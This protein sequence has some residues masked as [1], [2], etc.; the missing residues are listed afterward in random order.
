MGIRL[1]AAFTLMTILAVSICTNAFAATGRTPGQFAVSPTGTAQYTIPIWTPPG[2]RGVQPSLSLTYDS[3]SP[4][5]I[6]GVGW[7]L[8][9]VSSIY[10]CNP[11]YAQDGTPGA[12]TLTTADRFCMDGARLRLTSSDTLSNY[13]AVSTTY[14]TEVANFSL[15]TASATAAGNGPSYFTVQAKNG[16]TYEYGNT[17]DSKML[18]SSTATTPYA[19]ALDKVTDRAGNQMIFTYTQLDGTYV[20][21]SIQY[22]APSG[23]TTFPYEVTFG[24]S[25]RTPITKFVAGSQTQQPE[26]LSTI[27]VTSS[28]ATVRQ[29]NL[30]YVYSPTTGRPTLN[31]IQECGNPTGSGGTASDC[32]AATTITDQNGAVG[33]SAPSTATASG[34]TSGAVY[35]VDID[36]DGKQDLVYGVISGS[37]YQ[38][39]VQFSTGSG[40]RTPINTGAVSPIPAA[41]SY[42]AVQTDL[43]IDDFNATGGNQILAAVG[44]IWYSYAWNGTGFTA[45][46]IGLTVVAN[47]QYAS[48]DVDGDGRPDLVYIVPGYQSTNI[49]V[50][51]NTSTASAISFASTAVVTTQPSSYGASVIYGNNQL[52][53]SLIKHYDFDGDGR[54]DLIA[55][56]TYNVLHGQVG[57]QVYMSRYPAAF[58]AGL[59]GTIFTTGEAYTLAAVNWND[60]SCTDLITQAYIS[61]S[62]CNGATGGQLILPAVASLALDW[63]GDGRTDA[64]ANVGGTWEVYRSEGTAFA[65]G[66]STGIPVTG[67]G[68]Y[69]VTDADGDGLDD[70]VFSNSG[71][72]GALYYGLHSDAFQPPDL[73]ISFVDGFGNSASPTYVP[74][75]QGSFVWGDQVFPYQNYIGPMYIAVNAV[76]SDPSSASGATYYQHFYYAG[77]SMNLQGRGFAGF[78]AQQVYDSRNGVWE[79]WNRNRA[80]PYTGMQNY[81]VSAQDNLNAKPINWQTNTLT[82]LTLDG[83]AN[84]QRYLPY[85]SSAT[86]NNYEVG[87][88]KNA[89]LITSTVTTYSTPDSYGNFGTVATTVTDEDSQSP[90]SPYYGN[91]WTSTTVS[92]ITADPGTWCLNLPTEIQVT[93][94]SSAPGGAAITRTVTYTPDYT[95]CRETQQ[96]NEPSSSTYKVT[97]AYGYDNFG[98]LNSQTVTGVGM[99]ARTTGL[100]WGT[101]GQFLTTVTNA[102]SQTTT[103]GH[104]PASGMLTSLK[105]PNGITTSWQYDDFARR[106][107]ES[108]PDGTST[109]WAYSPCSACDPLPRM[110][111]TTQ[112]LDTEGHV[113]TT[114]D[115][116]FDAL[117]RQIYQQNTLLSGAKTWSAIRYFDSLGRVVETP[118]PYLVGSSPLGYQTYAYDLVNRVTQVQRPISA[119]NSTLQTTLYTYQG[120]TSTV[121]DPLLNVTTKIMQ[122]TGNVGRSMGA[123]GYYQNFTYDAFGS[124]LTTTDSA[125]PANTLHASTYA[126]GVEPFVTASTDMDMGSW[127]YTVD[128]L[129]EVTSYT[130]AKANSFSATYDALSRPTGLTALDETIVWNWGGNASTHDIGNLHYATS[131]TSAGTFTET[132]TYD[133][134]GRVSTKA[135][136][137]P[138]DATYTYTWTYN[139]TTGLLDT[140]Q[141]PASTSYQLKLQYAYANRILTSISDFNA[142]STVFWT[143]NTTNPRGQVTEE[144]LGNGAVTN[145]SY[146]AVTGWLG[147]STSGAGGGTGLQNIAFAY[148]YVGNVVQRQNNNRGLTENYYYDNMNRLDHSTLGGT[149]NLQ[150]AYDTVGMGNIASRS[151]VASGAAWTYDPVHKHEVTQAGSSANSYSYD[152]NGNAITRNGSAITWWDSNYPAS[153]STS[154]EEVQFWYGPDRQRWKEIYTS[155]AGTETTYHAA[156]LLEKVATASNTDYRHYIYVGSELV[157]IYSRTTAGTNTMYYVLRDHQGGIDKIDT[158]ANPSSTYVNESFTPYG[159]R[160]NGETWSGAPTTADETAISAVSRRGYTGETVLGVSMGLNHLNGRVEDAI[161]GRFLS[162]DPHIPNRSDTQSFNRYSYANNNPVTRVDPS[163]FNDCVHSRKCDGGGDDGGAGSGGG[164]GGDDGGAGSGGGGGGGG[165]DDGGAGSGGGGGDGGGGAGGGGDDGGGDGGGDDGGG[166]GGGDDG[167]GGGGSPTSNPGS[168]SGTSSGANSPPDYTLPPV[169]CDQNGLTCPGNPP[170]APPPASNPPSNP[171]GSPPIATLPPVGCEENGLICHRPKLPPTP[172]PPAPP[173]PPAPPDPSPPV[174]PPI[175]PPCEKV[176]GAAAGGLYTPRSAVNVVV[177]GFLNKIL[178]RGALPGIVIG[179]YANFWTYATVYNAY[180][181]GCLAGSGTPGVPLIGVP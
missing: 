131:T 95:N 107:G 172:P 58:V 71:A 163:G 169:G 37:N 89:D 171:P 36:G 151:D 112:V 153:I 155:S 92:T 165:G 67:T 77:A 100:N 85:A 69:V 35:S 126:Y 125:S 31:T 135:L 49:S 60:D 154:S 180:L 11:T 26:Q 148:D 82:Y 98:N 51:L 93:N 19:W 54:Q 114:S 173:R 124:L 25:T 48:A 33:V 70:L 139:A 127:S 75:F 176:A 32:L 96:V 55:V 91:T 111:V 106:N 146:D 137:L 23:S 72:S 1:H 157:G 121:K 134:D 63:D 122:V 130:D 42:P 117:D 116:Y 40:Y 143:A 34:A 102:L 9:G 90:A 27:I 103:F 162:P 149:L 41:S 140:L 164:S 142:P 56:G 39:W 78:G 22:T 105:D 16:W 167:G 86:L 181:T 30:V 108:R 101:T 38:W 94:S 45:T 168:S 113:I 156:K 178:G 61:I 2:I 158:G 179:A 62:A 68:N 115:Q 47:A 53:N 159:N 104:D 138:G 43:L 152:A 120:R 7:N 174:A 84:N 8:T 175:S 6:V 128:P 52:P 76:F 161:T 18:A 74:I 66:V 4:D 119:T 170:S 15:V 10:R 166:D 136:A 24:Y 83:T 145:R 133:S 129:G 109:T 160:R 99:S 88:S 3:R 17:S 20:L 57:S 46:S 141:Y 73:A 123:N 80:F 97:T 28:S 79:T 5:G 12:I 81:D 13:G 150:M 64:L 132:Y 14:Q 118:F 21:A 144:T 147:S 110:D 59:A 29:Y 65:A 50:Q 177:G 44:G 87:G